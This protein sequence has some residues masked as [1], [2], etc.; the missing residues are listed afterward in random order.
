MKRKILTGFRFPYDRPNRLKKCS[1][2]RDDHMETLA[3]ISQTTQTTETALMEDRVYF[4]AIMWKR[5]QTTEIRRLFQ[6]SLLYPIFCFSY[7][8][9]SS[10]R[11]S[12][13]KKCKNILQF[14]INFVK[15]Y[16]NKFKRMN[17]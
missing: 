2:G 14:I 12:F 6:K 9:R 17:I 13:W 15:G 16:K 7:K 3:R 10:T 1:D 8:T 4:E 5:C 11:H